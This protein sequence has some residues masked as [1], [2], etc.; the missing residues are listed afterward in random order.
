MWVSGS[1]IT[2][3]GCALS[4]VIRD[5]IHKP[6]SWAFWAISFAYHSIL[7]NGAAE[8]S[9]E[10]GCG[11]RGVPIVLPRGPP[12]TGITLPA[13]AGQDPSGQRWADDAGLRQETSPALDSQLLHLTRIR[14][15]RFVAC[16]SQFRCHPSFNRPTP[17]EHRHRP[18]S[19]AP[20]ASR[21]LTPRP[22]ALFTSMWNE[23]Y[24][25][26]TL[27][28]CSRFP[29]NTSQPPSSTTTAIGFHFPSSAACSTT[30]NTSI[31]HHFDVHCLT[32]HSRRRVPLVCCP[33]LG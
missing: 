18:T 31:A 13:G 20:V 10:G 23:D 8:R 9:G 14:L 19:A 21:Q 29:P 4:S 33:A 27:P 7:R 22:P 24:S 26:A 32:F 5:A 25:Q 15:V 16:S 2:G 30:N 28:R 11:K 3:H 12:E 17:A 1:Y 6:S